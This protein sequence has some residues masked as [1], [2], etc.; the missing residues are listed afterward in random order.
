MLLWSRRLFHQ[1]T[2]AR[3]AN[4]TSA[5]VFSG[6]GQ[7]RPG[8]QHSVLYRL[9]MLSMRAVVGVADAADGVRDAFH[10]Q[11]LGVEQ[12]GVLRPGVVVLGELS[13]LD[14]VPVVL[15][16]PGRHPQAGQHQV[17]GAGRRGVPADDALRV[18]VDDERDEHEAGPGAHVGEVRDPPLVRGRGGEV[19]LQ[20]VRRARRR[21]RVS[22]VVR[23]FLPRRTPD[24]PRSRMSRSTVW[25]DTRSSA[26]TWRCLP[27]RRRCAVIFRRPYRPSGLPRVASSAST[28]TASLTVRAATC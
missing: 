2:Q 13:G 4:S 12:R 14:R 9:M 15:A 27:T 7:E 23:S 22:D 26:G 24:S 20:P 18:H 17:S 11:V 1:S 5:R 16:L 3:V 21:C 10:R 19:P 25:C 8:M 6:P 28:T